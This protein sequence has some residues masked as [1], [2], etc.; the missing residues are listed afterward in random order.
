MQIGRVADGIRHAMGSV[1]GDREAVDGARLARGAQDRERVGVADVV[2][3]GDRPRPVGAAPAAGP[4]PPPCRRR[5][6]AA[7]PRRAGRGSG[8]ARVPRPRARCRAAPGGRHLAPRRGPLRH[9][10]GR[11]RTD[12]ST[13]RRARLGWSSRPPTPVASAS[14]DRDVRL[15]AW[16]VRGLEGGGPGAARQPAGLQAVVAEVLDAAHPDA[17]RRIA[18]GAAGQDRRPAAVGLGGSDARPAG[19]ASGER[20]VRWRRPS[21][22]PNRAP[23]SHRSRTRPGSGR[24][25]PGGSPAEPGPPPHRPGRGERS[26]RDGD[27]RE[28]RLQ[29]AGHDVGADAAERPVA[30]DAVR[31][32]PEVD[33]QDDARPSPSAPAVRVE[34]EREG[35]RRATRRRPRPCPRPP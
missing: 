29:S 24:A 15:E 31:V 35:R 5:R 3:E 13:R 1:D 18:D 19:G 27:V 26:R 22:R 12:P 17:G 32:D 33:R 28:D 4:S 2:P 20:A 8:R 9:G 16:L 7:G 6:S 23:A 34:A 25:W 21:G 11:P 30:H 10:S 14:G